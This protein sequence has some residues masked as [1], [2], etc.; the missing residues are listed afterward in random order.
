MMAGRSCPGLELLLFLGIFCKP[1]TKP[2]HQ[3][4]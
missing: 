4:V 2:M 3:I 1:P